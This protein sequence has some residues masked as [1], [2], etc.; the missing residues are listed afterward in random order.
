VIDLGHPLVR[1]AGAL[2][3][4]NLERVVVDTTA[5]SKTAAHPADARLRHRALEKPVAP[6]RREGAPPLDSSKIVSGNPGA[7]H[8]VQW[9]CT[10]S[11]RTP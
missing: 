9:I 1:K 3:T 4:E 11:S 6:A 10:G 8:T 5:Q 2:A 7:V